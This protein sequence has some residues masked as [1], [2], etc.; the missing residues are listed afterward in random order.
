MGTIFLRLLY[1]F[2]I[3]FS[4]AAASFFLFHVVPSD[5]VRTMLGPNA[6]EI[7]VETVRHELG[8]DRPI[9]RQFQHYIQHVAALDF[10]KSYVDGRSVG[11]E[12]GKRFQV[13]LSLAAVSILIIFFYLVL[14]SVLALMGIGARFSELSDFLCV[15]LPTLFAGFVIA[16]TSI[17]YYPYTRFSGE[18]GSLADWLF[19]FPPAFVLSLYPMGILGR[20][21]RKQFSELRQSRYVLSAQALGLSRSLIW[22]RYILR[23]AY[24]PLLAAFG[25]QIPFLVSSTFIVELIFSVPGIGAL[26]LRSVLER[27]LPMLEGIVISTSIVVL[28][29]SC[30]LEVLYPKADPRIRVSG[31]V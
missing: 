20:I 29:V 3:W 16:L 11:G 4:I 1:Y 12:L 18:M 21:L 9:H 5:P 19:L 8:L 7:Q 23:N 25:N 27:D 2:S 6:S 30:A 17:K 28:L 31:D 24:V 14:L 26:L 15:S 22:R 13:S 10:G